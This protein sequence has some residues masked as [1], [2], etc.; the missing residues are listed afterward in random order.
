MCLAISCTQTKTKRKIKANQF[1]KVGDFH[2][3]THFYCD[4]AKVFNKNHVRAYVDGIATDL[5]CETIVIT[6][7]Y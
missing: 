7:N 2:Y 3:E 6:N 5:M 4:S 1:Y